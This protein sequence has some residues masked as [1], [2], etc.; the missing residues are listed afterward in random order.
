MVIP[1]RTLAAFLALWLAAKIVFV[2]VVIPRRT[3]GRDAAATA[4][5]LRELVPAGEP[6]YLLKLK[7]EGVL[8]YYAR[9]T[10]KLSSPA[11]LPRNAHVALIE[12]EWKEWEANRAG[13]LVRW[14]YDQQGDPLILARVTTP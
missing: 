6:L 5:V 14:M 11:N 10:R 8:F 9:P 4:A 12:A 13:E 7:D 3:A 2:E 1:T